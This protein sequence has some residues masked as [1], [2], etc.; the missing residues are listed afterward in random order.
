MKVKK[1][2]RKTAHE[3]Y[4][5]I[6]KDNQCH[7]RN[8]KDRCKEKNNLTLIN[9][10]Y[11]CSNHEHYYDFNIVDIN[12]Q[13]D[14]ATIEDIDEDEPKIEENKDKKRDREDDEKSKEKKTKTEDEIRQ[15]IDLLI[16]SGK[17]QF[18]LDDIKNLK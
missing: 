4:K 2:N 3:T 15:N 5:N 9:G 6:D 10:F 11:L 14:I 12:E 18:T 1:P 17:K 16:R 7:G 13:L 8:D